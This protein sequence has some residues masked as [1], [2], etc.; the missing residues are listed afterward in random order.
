MNLLASIEL[1]AGGPGSGCQGENCGRPATG[2]QAHKLG[3]FLQDSARVFGENNVWSKLAKYGHPGKVEPFTKEE[4]K[5][6]R[7][8]K[9]GVGSCKVGQCIMNAQKL[10]IT[11]M[12]LD[13]PR[14]KYVEGLV[15]VYGVPIDHAWIEFNGKVYDPTLAD[16]KWRMK[17][18]L[19]LGKAIEPG[20][21]FGV[22]V[23]KNEI[24]TH[25]LKTKMYDFMSHYRGDDRLQQKIWK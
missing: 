4:Q 11:S 7:R 15:L 13:D 16:E 12:G 6:L 3:K 14:V 2:E 18:P 23:P 5:D 19:K 9:S 1:H 21:Y 17:N 20:E 10:A 8:L 24:M 22:E 25:Q